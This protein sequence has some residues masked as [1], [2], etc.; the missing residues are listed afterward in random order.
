MAIKKNKFNLSNYELTTCDIGQLVP[1]NV[2]EVLP[3]DTFKVRSQ[4]FARMQPMLAPIMHPL[5]VIFQ[6]WY[7]PNRLLWQPVP[8]LNSDKTDID[9]LGGWEEFYSAGGVEE[10]YPAYPTVTLT[11]EDCKAGSLANHMGIPVVAKG[12]E[13]SALP[14]RMYNMI[15]NERYRDEDIEP[16]IDIYLGA[17]EDKV[18][19]R[20]LLSPCWHRDYFTTARL[21][22]QRGA[23]VNVPVIGGTTSLQRYVNNQYSVSAS[24]TIVSSEWNRSGYFVNLVSVDKEPRSEKITYVSDTEAT[25]EVTFGAY[26]ESNQGGMFVTE[27]TTLTFTQKL[28]LSAKTSLS[29]SDNQIIEPSPTYS[30]SITSVSVSGFWVHSKLSPDV[31]SSGYISISDLATASHLQ[32]LKEKS[33]KYGNRYEE[34]I[35]LEFG[36][37]PA[38]ARIDRPQYLGGSEQT[39]QISEVLQTAESA[40]SGVGT[41]R[42]HGT[43]FGK[44]NRY[45]FRF[46]E[47][48]FV[49]TLMSIRPLALYADCLD[50]QW[51][52][53]TP[54]DH[55]LPDMAAAGGFEEVWQ[56]EVYGS[57]A[58]D[59]VVFG[60]QGKY[61]SY[62]FRQ[63]RVSGD[64]ATVLDYWHL[65]RKFSAPP[66]MNSSFLRLQS[67][68]FKRIFNLT[69]K[70]YGSILCMI[71]NSVKSYRPIDK[72]ARTT[73]IA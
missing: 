16:E 47:H 2:F 3:N 1:V 72:R 6:H 21:S 14:F 11:E 60:Y 33:I 62:R 48:G 68:D 49:M 20:N 70:D 12:V 37:R 9:I 17:G 27:P 69:D 15:W 4:L 34:R 67:G 25:L 51:L 22:T 45:R 13:V 56:K 63:N 43:T 55:Y 24:H 61:D 65:A 7:I 29:D 30:T 71:K 8:V 23:R 31:A 32:K 46:P 28:T 5:K 18:T 64:F 73:S 50:R 38:D 53:K 19:P 39:F 57:K 54:F 59:G 52:R 58:T 40:N 42:G 36:T 44:S 10:A 41:M 35:Q 26:A 66:V